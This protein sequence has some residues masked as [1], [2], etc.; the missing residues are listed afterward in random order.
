[1]ICRSIHILA[2]RDLLVNLQP[3]HHKKLIKYF[4]NRHKHSD[5]FIC[6]MFLKPTFAWWHLYM[7]KGELFGMLTVFSSFL[8][9]ISCKLVSLIMSD[10]LKYL[11]DIFSNFF[12][13]FQSKG[14]RLHN[15]FEKRVWHSHVALNVK[16]FT[17]IWT[18]LVTW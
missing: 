16:K 3:Y 14:I 1:M 6:F 2:C 10:L 8:S 9:P 7:N 12:F 18:W 17:G 4:L 13:N 5:V 15:V 11:N